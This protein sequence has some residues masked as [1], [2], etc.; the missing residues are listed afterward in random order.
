MDFRVFFNSVQSETLSALNLA[1][2]TL[3]LQISASFDLGHKT[4]SEIGGRFIEEYITQALSRH[5][6]N[7]ADFRFEYLSSRSLG[8]Y[9][10]ESRTNSGYVL[11]VDIKAQHMTI[12]EETEKYYKQNGITQ[13][14]PG[15]SHPNLISYEKAKEFYGDASRL[16]EDIAILN[17]KYAPEISGGKVDFKI[18]QMFPEQLFLLRT[19]SEANLSF[20]ALGKGQ[21]QLSRL[22]ALAFN[23]RNKSEFLDLVEKIASRPRTT[24]GTSRA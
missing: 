11:Y 8:D 23:E 6:E 2:K 17:V 24:R 10:I 12:R 14:K 15:E 7:S 20:G 13:K 3:P 16:F 4:V 18:Q 21:I 1:G 19:L 9:K 22:N 5:F